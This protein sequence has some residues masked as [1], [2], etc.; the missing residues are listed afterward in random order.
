MTRHALRFLAATQS[1]TLLYETQLTNHAAIR[2]VTQAG[3]VR[4]VS[5]HTFHLWID[6]P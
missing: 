4:T 1:G 3:F 5:R 2:S 6:V